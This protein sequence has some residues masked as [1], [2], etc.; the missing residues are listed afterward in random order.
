MMAI[1]ERGLPQ[2]PSTQ[3]VLLSL[4]SPTL[5]R[6][7]A[8]PWHVALTSIVCVLSLPCERACNLPYERLNSLSF[9]CAPFTGGINDFREPE[10]TSGI[11]R[12]MGRVTSTVAEWWV[13]TLAQRSPCPPHGPGHACPE[14]C[15]CPGN[16][17]LDVLS[18]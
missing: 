5:L 1:R 3:G 13:C 18:C 10:G 14:A 6:L 12:V 16:T 11:S 9:V 4:S 17:C 2:L 8:R 7:P 15:G